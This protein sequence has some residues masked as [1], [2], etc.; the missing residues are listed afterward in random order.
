MTTAATTASPK[1]ATRRASATVTDEVVLAVL[2][3]NRRLVEAVIQLAAINKPYQAPI[4]FPEPRQLP[5]I[6]EEVEDAQFAHQAGMID[7]N[8]LESVLRGAGFPSANIDFMR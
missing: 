5:G 6:S 8:E 3:Q 1:T 7:D 4:Q 2:D